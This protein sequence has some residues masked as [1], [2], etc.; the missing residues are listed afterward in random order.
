MRFSHPGEQ[1]TQIIVYFSD[2]SHGGTR[3]VRS[4]FLLDGDGWRQPFDQID[5]R[6]FH[7]LQKLS[8]IGGK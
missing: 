6:F 5:I 1:Q 2:S 4:G 8:G 7:Q 3:I